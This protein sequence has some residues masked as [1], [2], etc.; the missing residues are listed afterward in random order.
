MT[1]YQFPPSR[2]RARPVQPIECNLPFQVVPTCGHDS[3][4]AGFVC[5]KCPVIDA[6]TDKLC[7]PDASGVPYDRVQMRS[8]VEYIL[9]NGFS[10]VAPV[11][12]QACGPMVKRGT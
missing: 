1:V 4:H 2:I 7:S 8:A 3:G 6:V 12:G 10:I 11:E 9:G 5:D